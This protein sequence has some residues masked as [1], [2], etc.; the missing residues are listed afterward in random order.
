ML[1]IGLQVQDWRQNPHLHEG[2]CQ[3]LR[4]DPSCGHDEIFKKVFQLGGFRPRF[5]SALTSITFPTCLMV[6][7]GLWHLWDTLI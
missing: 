5:S 3:D 2:S 1:P 4:G 6:S 7:K